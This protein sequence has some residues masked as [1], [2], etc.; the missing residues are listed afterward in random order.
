MSTE[1]TPF[2]DHALTKETFGRALGDAVAVAASLSTSSLFLK[3][4]QADTSLAGAITFGADPATEVDPNSEWALDVQ[5]LQHGWML[6]EKATVVGSRWYPLAEALPSQPK[7]AKL[8]YRG[9][10]RCVSP[11]HQGTQVEFG[12]DSVYICRFF[13]QQM[14]PAIQARLAKVDD[15]TIYPIL[16]MAASSYENKGYNKTIYT[17]TA[18][19]VDWV[20]RNLERAGEVA[21]FAPE[22]VEDAPKVTPRRKRRVL[23]TDDLGEMS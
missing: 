20:G 7:G 12:G 9:K 13:T 19:I 5:D 17:I 4:Q 10:L 22:V 16:R 2:T 21:T 1:M 23:N 14:F 3:V 18:R 11:H 15:G 6:R 8:A